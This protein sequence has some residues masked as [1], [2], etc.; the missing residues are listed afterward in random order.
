MKLQQWDPHTGDIQDLMREK[1]TNDKTHLTTIQGI[2]SLK[3]YH[4]VFW[5]EVI[6]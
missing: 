6:E 4:S 5:M 1:I 2:M 3:F